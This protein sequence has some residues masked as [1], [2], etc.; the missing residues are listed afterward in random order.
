ML[1]YPLTAGAGIFK[2]RLYNESEMEKPDVIAELNS[3]GDGEQKVL[4]NMRI[5]S[6]YI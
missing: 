1:E 2:V 6:R 3:D 5:L 4:W